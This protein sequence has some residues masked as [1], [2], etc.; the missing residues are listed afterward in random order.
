MFQIQNN[1]VPKWRIKGYDNYVFGN[2]KK[3]YN[4]L[5]EKEVKPK[6]KSYTIGYNIAGKFKSRKQLKMM[7]IK[8]IESDC[9]F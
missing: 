9:P 8:Y 1:I 4:L 6:L 2:D 3:L 7:L 5:R